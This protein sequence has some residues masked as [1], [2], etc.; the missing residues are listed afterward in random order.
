MQTDPYFGMQARKLV[1]PSANVWRGKA[2][3]D[4]NK[5]AP[6]RTV[7]ASGAEDRPQRRTEFP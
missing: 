7:E 4:T 2:L 3:S 5:Q 6:T 1:V